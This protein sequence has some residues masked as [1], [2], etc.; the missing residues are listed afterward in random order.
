MWRGGQQTEGDRRNLRYQEKKRSRDE[1]SRAKEL[2][3]GGRLG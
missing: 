3:R 1:I 2:I